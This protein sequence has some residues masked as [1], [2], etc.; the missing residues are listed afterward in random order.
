MTRCTDFARSNG[1]DDGSDVENE[2]DRYAAYVGERNERGHSPDRGLNFHIERGA[3]V[4]RCVPGW[5]PDDTANC[6]YGVLVE[7]SV[8][9][10]GGHQDDNQAE[11]GEE[12]GRIN[13]EKR[14]G[15]ENY[16]HVR[17]AV[18]TIVQDVLAKETP[19]DVH[20]PLMGLGLD[21]LHVTQLVRH[22]GE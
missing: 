8:N 2:I 5:R 6:G 20:A 11:G 16:E 15:W 19:V 13:G 17:A 1:H 4:V 14:G 21:S 22:L 3:K 9:E 18:G 10:F 7:Y 12:G